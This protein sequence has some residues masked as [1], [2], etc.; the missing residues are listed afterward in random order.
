[1]WPQWLY[2]PW[3][4][5]WISHL[6]PTGPSVCQSLRYYLDRTS[7]LRQNQ[8][9]VFVSFK[10]GFNKDFSPA[11]FSSSIKQTL[12]LCFELSDQESLI[13]H[14]VKAY[15]VRSFAASK[16]FQPRVS[17][18]Q[19]ISPCHWKPHTKFFP[20]DVAWADS[21]FYHFGPV[22]AAQHIYK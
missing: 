18:E 22:V 13:L 9:L 6:G 15:E 5:L 3:P 21:E 4:P 17:L 19:I 20:K 11:I 14:Q 16:A 10:K 1:M 8:K 2:Q 7:N 12:I